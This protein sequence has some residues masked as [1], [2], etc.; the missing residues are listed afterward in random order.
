MIVPDLNLLI[1]A[2]D[3]LSPQHERA[4]RWWLGV[5]SGDE[6]VGLCDCVIFGFIRLSTRRGVFAHPLN[7]D[8]A[9]AVAE[10]WVNQPNVEVLESCARSRAIAFAQL[11]KLGTGGNLTTDCQI[12]ALALRENATVHS[13]DTDMLRFDGLRVHNPLA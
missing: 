5:L 13:N 3:E 11:R 8:D 12:A 4:Q 9:L 7:I 6:A 2:L 10:E 1:Y